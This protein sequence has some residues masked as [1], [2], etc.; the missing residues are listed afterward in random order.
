M[1]PLRRERERAKERGE[2]GKGDREVQAMCPSGHSE[3]VH[4]HV[5]LAKREKSIQAAVVYEDEPGLMCRPLYEWPSRDVMAST[6]WLG[7]LK[8]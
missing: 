4:A 7:L 5:S 3:V 1:P 6:F 8:A 2:L